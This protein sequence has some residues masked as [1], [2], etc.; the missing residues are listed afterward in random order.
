M[1]DSLERYENLY[2]YE[3]QYPT[4]C[5]EWSQSGTAVCVA[6]FSHR[7]G[8][9]LLQ[10]ALPEKLLPPSAQSLCARRDFK[11]LNGGFSTSAISS[12][13]YLPHTDVIA[14]CG[15]TSTV[16]LW[17]RDSEDTALLTVKSELRLETCGAREEEEAGCVA[18]GRCL[19]DHSPS[20]LPNG[21]LAGLSYCS[22]S[23][24]LIDIP[25]SKTTFQLLPGH[26]EK[27]FLHDLCFAGSSTSVFISCSTPVG[28]LVLCDP[29]Q[30]QPAASSTITEQPPSSHTTAAAAPPAS[31][32]GV[33]ATSAPRQFA[34]AVSNEP[35][36]LAKVAR[37]S[38]AGEL[39]LFDV[40]KLTAP[41]SQT[42]VCDKGRL[43]T[44]SE[45]HTCVQFCQFDSNRVSVSGPCTGVKVLDAASWDTV[46]TH[47]GHEQENAGAYVLVHQ[48]GPSIEGG[49]K[50]IIYSADSEGSMHAWQWR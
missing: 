29:A 21:L 43:T 46:F 26:K 5:M 35:F 25:T 23:I 13:R 28:V 24:Q 18:P 15:G 30:P 33:S 27:E 2:M 39:C 22:R 8:N 36:P 14:S 47:C 50:D 7:H 34:V 6:G 12:L 3:M 49:C 48:W 19:I 44:S 32:N 42:D 37:L 17:S 10:L 11:M 9:E 40:R 45:N 1:I 41:L 38:C 16:N 31:P 4:Q 20:A